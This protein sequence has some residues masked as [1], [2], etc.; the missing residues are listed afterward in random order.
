[1]TIQEFIKSVW[2]DYLFYRTGYPRKTK[3]EEEDNQTG[4]Y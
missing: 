1:M 2:T 4:W 3:E